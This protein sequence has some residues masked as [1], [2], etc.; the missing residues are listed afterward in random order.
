MSQTNNSQ[1]NF[2]IIRLSL[3]QTYLLLTYLQTDTTSYCEFDWHYNI[4]KPIF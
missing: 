3:S 1:I 2:E 4:Y